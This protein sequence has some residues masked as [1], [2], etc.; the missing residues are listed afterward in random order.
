MKYSSSIDHF[1]PA[2]YLLGFVFIVTGI[3][4]RKVPQ[5]R[6]KWWTKLMW[7]P[8]M[9][10]DYEVWKATNR[11]M[12]IPFIIS[13]CIFLIYGFFRTIFE[14]HSDPFTVILLVLILLNIVRRRYIS[15]NS[16]VL[17]EPNYKLISRITGLT[18]IAF[19]LN[20]CDFIIGFIAVK[21][22]STFEDRMVFMEKFYPFG[23]HPEGMNILLLILCFLSILVLAPQTKNANLFKEKIYASMTIIFALSALIRLFWWIIAGDLITYLK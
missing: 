13:G 4:Y 10:P 20:I 3:I 15:M 9:D 23:I 12:A 16:K 11:Y 18:F 5:N 21:S 17:A 19:M 22:Q 2:V 14:I 1:L 6:D 8:Y 7:F